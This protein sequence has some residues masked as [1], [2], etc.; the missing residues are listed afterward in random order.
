MHAHTGETLGSRRACPGHRLLVK[1]LPSSPNPA[2]AEPEEEAKK[3]VE[4][5]ERT[6]CLSKLKEWE[7]QR[8]I[9]LFLPWSNP[10]GVAAPASQAPLI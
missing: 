10:S 5:R 3:N 1:D 7:P 8:V 4:E 2:R 9:W 6:G